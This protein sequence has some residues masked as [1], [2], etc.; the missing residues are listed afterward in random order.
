MISR[1]CEPLHQILTKP[2]KNIFFSFTICTAKDTKSLVLSCVCYG[3]AT[4]WSY[5][6]PKHTLVRIWTVDVFVGRWTFL[7]PFVTYKYIALAMHQVWTGTTCRDCSDP[8][9][10]LGTIQGYTTKLIFYLFSLSFIQTIQQTDRNNQKTADKTRKSPTFWRQ[11]GAVL[12]LQTTD[13]NCWKANQR[14][15]PDSTESQLLCLSTVNIYQTVRLTFSFC[16]THVR[17]AYP[18]W[19]ETFCNVL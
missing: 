18:L 17:I 15:F 1:I 12:R 13:Y 14:H 6:H 9:P 8:I 7:L 3:T 19:K 2:S 16:H 4:Y 5:S 10:T 11:V